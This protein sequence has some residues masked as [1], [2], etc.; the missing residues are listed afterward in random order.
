VA[1]WSI[2]SAFWPVPPVKERVGTVWAPKLSRLSV[3]LSLPALPVIATLLMVDMSPMASTAPLSDWSKTSTR[4][5]VWICPPTSSAWLT[6]W[7]SRSWLAIWFGN[8][9]S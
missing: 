8:V 3:T 1:E 4:C 6:A 2:T 5:T 9:A 7:I